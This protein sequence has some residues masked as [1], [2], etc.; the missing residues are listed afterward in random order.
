MLTVASVVGRIVPDAVVAAVVGEDTTAALAAITRAGLMHAD[1]ETHSFVHDL[2]RETVRDPVVDRR[3][4]RHPR[5]HRPGIDQ[6]RGG[7]RFAARAD[8]PG[9]RL[10]AVPEIPAEL[11]VELLE[12]AALD[13]S[14]RMTH[15][16]AGRHLET[17]ASL[18]TD[19]DDRI[20]LTLASGHAYLRAGEL[21]LARNRFASLLDEPPEVRA[22]ALL[23]LHALGE[24]AAG[25]ALTEVVRGLDE[26]HDELGP[27]PSR[28]CGPR[29]SPPAV[30]RVPTSSPM[31]VPRRRRW[32]LM[33]SSSLGWRAMTGRSRP[34]SSLITTPSGSREPSRL[35]SRSRCRAGRVG[36]RLHEPAFE[37]QG[38]LLA[39]VAELELGDPSFRHTHRRF[40]DVAEASCS[41]RL[42]FWAAS[43]RGTIATLDGDFGR[44]TAEIDAAHELG[45]RIGETDAIGRVVRPTVADRA[46]AG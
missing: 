41:Q 39:M 12:A 7:R 28:P 20:R 26:V 32:P 9:T 24:V 30:A 34:V 18:A 37:A 27:M 46:P 43:R 23:G 14:A 19:Q 1:R 42:R 5:R 10:Q 22:R 16:A 40:D 31:T 25:D 6:P 21:T 8:S 2:V 36:E 38:L 4:S 33:P 15:E 45:G 11:A 3:A 13:A 44:A 17:A 29:C 35:D